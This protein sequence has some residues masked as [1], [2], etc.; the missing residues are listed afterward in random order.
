M[1]SSNVY[2]KISLF[3]P[4]NISEIYFIQDV[5]AIRKYMSWLFLTDQHFIETRYLLKIILCKRT[6]NSNFKNKVNVKIV[7]LKY[8]ILKKVDLLVS[9]YLEKTPL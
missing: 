7:Y 1:H 5:D 3:N 8:L 2:G 4:Y 6:L 9:I